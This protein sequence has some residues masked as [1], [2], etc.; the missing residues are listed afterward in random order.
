MHP[1]RSN[2]TVDMRLIAVKAIIAQ[3]ALCQPEIIL[4]FG[5][6]QIYYYSPTI[7]PGGVRF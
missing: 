2:I 3:R 4:H 6:S 1:L 7:E 5:A